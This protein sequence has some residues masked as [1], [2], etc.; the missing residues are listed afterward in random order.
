MN[1]CRPWPIKHVVPVVLK[2]AF[3]LLAGIGCIILVS[4]QRQNSRAHISN[5]ADAHVPPASA[6]ASHLL[7]PAALQEA[8]R[9]EGTPHSHLHAFFGDEMFARRDYAAG[10]AIVVYC[11]QSNRTTASKLPQLDRVFRSI[12]DR[13][14]YLSHNMWSQDGSCSRASGSHNLRIAGEAS[15]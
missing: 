12:L 9:I 14:A 11:T 13:S 7:N 4:L 3:L 8:A 5:R 1:S 15:E 6:L 2:T 10:R